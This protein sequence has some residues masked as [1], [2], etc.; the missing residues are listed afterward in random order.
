VPIYRSSGL[1]IFF[2]VYARVLPLGTGYISLVLLLLEVC[3]PFQ[4]RV[5]SAPTYVYT[6]YIRGLTVSCVFLLLLKNY[7]ILM[8]VLFTLCKNIRKQ[9]IDKELL[10]STVKSIRV[11]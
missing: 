7:E 1:R 5:G 3:A 6:M 9:M 10:N 2:I 11:L 4:T 8:I